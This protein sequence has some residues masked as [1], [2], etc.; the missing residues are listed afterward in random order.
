VTPEAQSTVVKQVSK[1]R[2]PCNPLAP[3]SFRPYV[4]IMKTA[5]SLIA[6]LLLGGA[7]ATVLP[8]APARSVT[9]KKAAPATKAEEPPA[10]IEGM[11]I[12][13]ANGG[14]MGLEIADGTFKLR[15]YDAKKK[16]IAP[17][18]AQVILRW[19]SK[20]K[21]PRENVV[22]SSDGTLMTSARAIRPPYIFKLFITVFKEP[23]E[24]ADAV[25]SENYVVDF[26]QT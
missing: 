4:P 26:N 2:G 9:P 12:P 19:D 5:A 1:Q 23:A 7:L 16:K 20:V 22:L 24:G 11:E 6:A 15:F 8:A 3:A 10:K 18:V 21:A 13:R 14:F 25:P 17:D